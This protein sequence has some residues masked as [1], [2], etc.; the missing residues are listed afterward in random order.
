MQLDSEITANRNV[1][2]LSDPP[3]RQSPAWIFPAAG[4]GPHKT[5][6]EQEP[7]PFEHSFSSRPEDASSANLQFAQAINNAVDAG[8]V[9]PNGHSVVGTGYHNGY[10]S[11]AYFNN[12]GGAAV[13]GN[14][15]YEIGPPRRARS[16]SPKSAGWQHSTLNPSQQHQR[17]NHFN[18][19]YQD[20]SSSSYL[21]A[22]LFGSNSKGGGGAFGNI[23]TPSSELPSFGW[24]F[25]NNNNNHRS[26][27]PSAGSSINVPPTAPPSHGIFDPTSIRTGL[28][29]GVSDGNK[30]HQPPHSPATQALFAMMT[31]ATPGGD[32]AAH[33]G[34]GS[35]STNSNKPS[36]ASS[37]ST[38][39][40][41]LSAP[42]PIAG[43]LLQQPPNLGDASRTPSNN[44]SS[45]NSIPQVSN[46]HQ[47]QNNNAQGM[48]SQA[49]PRPMQ[50]QGPYNNNNTHQQQQHHLHSSYQGGNPS[51]LQ[52][53]VPRPFPS[54]AFDSTQSSE[55]SSSQSVPQINTHQQQQS[56]NRGGGAGDHN[57][58]Y[59][60][61]QHAQDGQAGQPLPPHLQHQPQS[62]PP[63]AVQRL[64]H[65]HHSRN[66]SDSQQGGAPG[67]ASSHNED[68]MLAAAALSGLSTPRPA[69]VGGPS[70]LVTVNPGSIN[71]SQPV[72][73]LVQPPLGRVKP[74]PPPASLFHEQKPPA[75]TK[76][77]M[78]ANNARAGSSSAVPNNNKKGSAAGNNKRKKG[79]TATPEPSTAAADE[80][81]KSKV[82]RTSRRT[83]ATTSTSQQ[84]PPSS[85][86]QQQQQQQ[87]FAELPDS[88][89]EDEIESRY[90][91]GGNDAAGMGLDGDMGGD[92]DDDDMM[93]NNGSFNGS[94]DGMGGSQAGDGSGVSPPRK[95]GRG[96]KQHFATEEEKRKN[97][98]ERNRQGESFTY[99]PKGPSVTCNAY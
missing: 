45:S 55:A 51:Y 71:P 92:S 37:S 9:D 25:D 88:G 50:P 43:G 21:G 64:Q 32:I 69:Y 24:A 19:A 28:T 48:Y 61:S 38:T 36:Q 84:Q 31:N 8:G 18:H 34:G 83:A 80:A 95:G 90:L 81:S 4:F 77:N 23:S 5:H 73:N 86:Q 11:N 15:Q 47:G 85:S 59:L 91:P 94:R 30:H 26:G 57:P 72:P 33:F 44:S 13:G 1:R 87:S 10:P 27:G 46:S 58:L 60:L 52:Q 17:N 97:F 41:G 54:R 16:Q 63:N 6:L 68:A 29:P 22:N 14:N 20:T 79:A 42:P 35:S 49:V 66:S 98:L 70:P 99:L 89:G 74:I 78:K 12:G 82:R 93:S 67:A 75:L 3:V 40:S 7:N 76:E 62:I 53:N 65:P 56:Q 39:H 2:A 96:P